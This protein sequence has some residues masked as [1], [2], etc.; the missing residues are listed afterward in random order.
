MMVKLVHSSPPLRAS[1]ARTTTNPLSSSAD[2]NAI[3]RGNS[4]TADARHM[5]HAQPS[6]SSSFPCLELDLGR[7]EVVWGL[8]VWNFN[9]GSREAAE[10]GA[11][12]ISVELDGQLVMPV[13]ND[14][15][16]GYSNHE[17]KDSS[18]IIC[19]APRGTRTSTLDRPFAW[20][21]RPRR[22]GGKR[23][24]KRTDFDVDD[25][26]QQQNQLNKSSKKKY[27]APAVRQDYEPCVLPRASAAAR[28]ALVLG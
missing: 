15:N 1:R 2:P 13:A 17:R 6:L 25:C 27:V 9:A 4:I 10:A 7:D 14:S 21:C 5:W 18:V 12:A 23:A 20:P 8:R 16:A 28:A 3:V 22:L 11:G 24:R 26:E 19:G